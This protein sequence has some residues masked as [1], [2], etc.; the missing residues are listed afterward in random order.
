MPQ[1]RKWL[2]FGSKYFLPYQRL[3][4]TPECSLTFGGAVWMYQRRHLNFYRKRTDDWDCTRRV[5]DSSGLSVWSRTPAVSPR[6][7]PSLNSVIQWH[8]NQ[9][10]HVS[11]LLLRSQFR[12]ALLEVPGEADLPLG[13]EEMAVCFTWR[14]QKLKNWAENAVVTASRIIALLGAVSLL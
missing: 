10:H 12:S 3:A 5:S 4:A 1:N 13:R 6:E 7:A 11:S 9:R 8:Q 2:C 14:G